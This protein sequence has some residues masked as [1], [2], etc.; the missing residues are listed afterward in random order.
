MLPRGCFSCKP[1]R[2]SGT[3][4]FRKFRILINYQPLNFLNF[5]K[6]TKLSHFCNFIVYLQILQIL[7]IMNI[8]KLKGM[9]KCKG[10]QYWGVRDSCS[11][12]QLRSICWHLLWHS[13]GQLVSSEKRLTTGLGMSA[14]GFEVE[15]GGGAQL[16]VGG[17]RSLQGMW[18]STLVWLKQIGKNIWHYSSPASKG[19]TLAVVL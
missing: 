1:P 8:A 16:E 3:Y 11:G 15:G 10:L 9:W 14:G 19:L 17:G 7:K 18:E 6:S 12:L 2:I 4:I 5:S 13:D